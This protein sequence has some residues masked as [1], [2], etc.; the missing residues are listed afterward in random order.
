MKNEVLKLLTNR[1][2]LITD[3]HYGNTT[4]KKLKIIYV[5]GHVYDHIQ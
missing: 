3:K 5:V 1:D 2:F 4:T